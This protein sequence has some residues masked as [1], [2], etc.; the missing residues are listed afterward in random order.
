MRMANRAD[1]LILGGG[2]IGLTT[3]YYL[4][5]RHDARVTVLDRGAMGRE[6]SWAGAGIIP[7]G[8]PEGA[9]SA[10]D[11]L[12]A[13]SSVLTAQLSAELRDAVGVDNGYRRCG[14]VELVADEPIDTDAWQCEGVEWQHV[15][16]ARLR[17]IEPLLASGL[18]SGYFL[19]GLAQMRNPR[20]LQ[21]LIA[22][23]AAHGVELRPGCQAFFIEAAG[24]RIAGV[25][26][27][28]GPLVA[29]QYLVTAGAWTD[30]LLAPL[31]CRL[32]T[33][34][35]RGQI[36]L[37]RGRVPRLKRI[38]LAGKR[39]LVPRDD[40]RV[41]V[42]STEE[43][44]GFDASTTAAAIGEL[45]RFATTLVPALGDAAVERCWAGL[46][47]GSPDGLPFLGRVP[48]FGNLWVAAGHF[49]AGLQLSAATGM[50]MAEALTGL[51][52]S[53]PL[54][55]FRP[56]RRPGSPAQPAFRS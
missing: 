53:I 23:S 10:Y 24:D 37:L 13:T 2:V 52:P 27:N 22:A 28:D 18:G 25:H 47:P 9:R 3:A 21:A 55:P 45:L 32:G 38:V 54:D 43:D 35:I 29:G 6:A 12:R 34:P 1:V 20:H 51:L 15:A 26:T 30:S 56:D 19:P 49:R 11:C 7:P 4:A 14:G 36:A 8:R 40:G 46:R 44:V 41:L 5:F 42:G 16:D 33:R 50:V 48:G 31:G 39:Y 17:E